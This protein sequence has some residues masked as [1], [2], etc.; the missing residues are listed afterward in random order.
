MRS[1]KPSIVIGAVCALAFSTVAVAGA[2]IT[3]SSG[4][5]VWLPSAPPSVAVNAQENATSAIAFDERQATTLTAAVVVD[6]VNPGTYSTFPSGSANIAAGT[7][8]DSHLIHSDPPVLASTTHRIGTVSF[9][10]DILGVI[11]STTR[12][13]KSDAALARPARPTPAALRTAASSRELQERTTRSRSA[14]IVA[15]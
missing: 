14:A 2:L 9:S 8:V 13:A 3:G 12:L 5:V 15:R 4:Q 6:A 7:E 1:A 10:T 11:G